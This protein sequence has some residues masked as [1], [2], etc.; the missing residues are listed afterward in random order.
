MQITIKAAAKLLNVSPAT[1]CSIS[2]RALR[3]SSADIQ[4]CI[5]VLPGVFNSFQNAD[6]EVPDL[7]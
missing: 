3:S 2:H 4:N 6:Q 7:S 1:V 5:I